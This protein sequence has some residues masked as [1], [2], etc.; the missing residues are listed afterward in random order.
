MLQKHRIERHLPAQRMAELRRAE[1]EA[2]TSL[3]NSQ[4]DPYRW[5]VNPTRTHLQQ[6]RVRD[7]EDLSESSMH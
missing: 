3:L 2:A 7:R 4:P 6:Q 1:S 5:E